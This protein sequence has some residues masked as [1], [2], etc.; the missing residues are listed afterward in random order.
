MPSNEGLY[1]DLKVENLSLLGLIDTGSTVSIIHTEKFDLLPMSIRETVSPT[2]CVLRMA[3]GG[4]VGCKGTTF[5]PLSIGGKVYNQQVLIADIEAPFVVGYD[6]LYDKQCSL[7]ISKGQLLFP[8]QT[9]DCKLESEMP[10]VFKIALSETVEI[11]AN[12]EMITSGIFSENTPHFSTAMVDEYTNKL[13][14]KGIFVAKS[15]I[16]TYNQVIPLR[17][18]NL[19]DFPTKLYKNETAAL[20]DQVAI[21][22]DSEQGGCENEIHEQIRTVTAE[23]IDTV[24]LPEHLQQMYEASIKNLTQDEAKL[25]KA[26]L[27]KHA[28]VFSKSRS[29]L[30]FCDIIPH[31]INT[32]LAP[33]IRIPP[34]RAPMTMKNAVD[35][36]VQRLIDNNLVVKSKSPWAFPLVPIKKKDGSIRICVDYRKLNEVTLHDSY[37]LPKI[38]ECL[39]ALQGAKWFSTIDATSG[40][41]QVQNHPD[42]MDKTAFVC[43]KGLFA[44]R[45]LPMGLRN[46]PATY[47]RLMVHIMSPLLYET[48]LVYLDDCIVYSRTFEEHIQRLDEVLTRMGKSNL[49]CLPKKCQLFSQEVQFLGHRVSSEGV[50]TCEDKVKAVKE[51]PVPRNIKELKSFLGLA[52]YYRR[53][54]KSFSTISAPL[55][56]LTQKKQ[57]FQ[58][59]AEA[60]DA[61]D[62]LKDTLT[63]APILG[64]PNTTDQYW[65]DCDASSFGISGV[66]SQIQDGTERVIAYFS[67]TLNRAQRQY[68]VTRRELLAIVESVKHFHQYLYGVE[69]IVRTD[70]GSITWLRNFKNPSAILARWLEVLNTYSFEIRF[71]SGIQHKNADAL[72]RRPC[73]SCAYCD[74][75]EQEDNEYEMKCNNVTVIQTPI[76]DSIKQRETT[77][78]STENV[79]DCEENPSS[80][81]SQGSSG[82]PSNL[83]EPLDD[84]ASLPRKEKV[85]DESLVAMNTCPFEL[86]TECDFNVPVRAVHCLDGNCEPACEYDQDFVKWKEV[87]VL[88]PVLS[89]IY[90]WVENNLRPKWEEISGTDEKTKTYW[91]QW[92]RLLLHK[93]VLCRRYLDV[94]TDTHFLQILVPCDSREE[95]LMQLHD[96]LT[97]GHLGTTKTIDKVKKRFYWYKYK[98]FIENWVQKCPQCQARR[99][100]KL[101]P[102]APMSQ[103]RVGVPMERVCLDLLG[104][105]P[106]SRNRNKYVLSI[107][108]QFTRW[109]ELFPIKNMEA[110]TIAKVFVNEF[111]SRYGLSR[112]ILTDQGRQFE[113]MLFKEI[114]VLM[115]IDKKRNTSFHPQTNGIQERFN[116]TIEDM[117][118]KFV[119]ANQR[120]WDEYLPLLLLAYRSS[121]HESTK[122]TPYMMFFGRHALLPVDLLCCP[123][124]NETKMTSNEY[125]LELQERLHKVHSIARTEMNKASAVKRKPMII[126]YM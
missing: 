82:L 111:V 103:N 78:R 105:F 106:E 41:F 83:K 107:V 75:R 15:V 98:E 59:T 115:D 8:D 35:E 1:L 23:S 7:D 80:A 37:P 67:K 117:L 60:Q 42:D 81:E 112:Q 108:D 79:S 87:Q 38:Q 74:R 124:C 13:A 46:S 11:P 97:A 63:K 20:C 101:R 89:I 109:V 31:R 71:R 50:A 52:S 12:S 28:S 49:K 19:N 3:D 14:E 77:P 25:I 4:P 27:L 95:V 69:F 40:F 10:R 30:G 72:S 121:V 47:Q 91:A 44:F 33:P 9:I 54:I 110:I 76:Q 2:R 118:S 66:L 22:S 45:V 102:K 90:D 65:L 36:E 85:K 84:G 34:R 56:K 86:E 32:G 114:C 21:H 126:G 68:C 122:Q 104:P 61:F 70:H 116:R 73:T 123:P 55:N 53:F 96:H 48:C 93:G 57:T 43:D 18:L 51:W 119:S 29:D 125:V 94:N 100:P 99:L 113:S 120:D 5:L 17:L 26:L 64:F 39:D 16:D 92:S 24:T 58:W 88:D 62:I 6:F